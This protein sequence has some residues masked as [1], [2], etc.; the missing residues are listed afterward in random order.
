MNDKK[1]A[2]FPVFNSQDSIFKSNIQEIGIR[3][4]SGSKRI[5]K[6]H[7]ILVQIVPLCQTRIGLFTLALKPRGDVIRSPNQGYQWPHK[8][9]LCPSKLKKNSG[10]LVQIHKSVD[11]GQNQLLC[12]RM[13]IA[14][15]RLCV[16]SNF[17]FDLYLFIIDGMYKCTTCTNEKYLIDLNVIK[18]K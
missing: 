13:C 7:I 8:K 10:K 6:M 2:W 15:K 17:P 1:T 4:F 5:F 18:S 9:D 11:F 3:T 14:G 12:Q 16:D